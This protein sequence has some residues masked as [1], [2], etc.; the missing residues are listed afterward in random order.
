M[1]E[2]PIVAEIHRTREKLAAKFDFDIDAFFVDV[3]K[4]QAELG[5]RLVQPKKQA[6]KPL[7]A[8]ISASPDSTST[9]A[10]PG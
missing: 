6:S 1:W 10:T 5:A 3:R 9:E 8:P 2:D 4:R 7:L